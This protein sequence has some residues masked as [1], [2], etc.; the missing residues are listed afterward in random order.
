VNN[1][2]IGHERGKNG[3]VNM[4][5]GTYPWLFVT[6]IFRNGDP[7]HGDYLKTFEVMTTPKPL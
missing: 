1:P 4:T 2:V 7:K 6:Q 3:N 5:N